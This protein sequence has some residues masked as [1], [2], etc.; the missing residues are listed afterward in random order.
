MTTQPPDDPTTDLAQTHCEWCGAS[1]DPA[2]QA[3]A[4][5]TEH[6]EAGET[7]EPHEPSTHCQCGAPYPTPKS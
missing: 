5:G 7:N 2:D 1:F 4:P 6:A 3:P